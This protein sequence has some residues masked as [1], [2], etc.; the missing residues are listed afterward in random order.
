[1]VK[2]GH[3]LCP[4]CKKKIQPI[5]EHDVLITTVYCHNCKA[6]FRVVFA[7]GELLKMDK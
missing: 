7:D 3:L 1:M 5:E 2:N 6:Y 4:R